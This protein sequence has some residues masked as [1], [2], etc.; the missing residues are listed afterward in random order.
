MREIPNNLQ[1]ALKVCHNTEDFLKALDKSIPHCQPTLSMT[2]REIWIRV[3]KRELIDQL[4]QI[5]K[6]LEENQ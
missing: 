4:L 3:G 1:E 6:T 2:E 5:H